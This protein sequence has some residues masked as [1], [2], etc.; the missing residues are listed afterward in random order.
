MLSKLSS[1]EKLWE[2]AFCCWLSAPRWDPCVLR[3]KCRKLFVSLPV[4]I[5]NLWVGVFCI[6]ACVTLWV[7]EAG[8]VCVLP[9][10]KLVALQHDGYYTSKIMAL[11]SHH[12]QTVSALLIL[13]HFVVPVQSHTHT[14]TLKPY[15]QTSKHQQTRLFE[16]EMLLCWQRLC[17][18]VIFFQTWIKFTF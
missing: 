4:W 3:H 2:G 11:Q 16:C 15:V 12:I 9:L 5:Y 1:C 17:E 14:H 10:C 6:W 7:E 13:T 8:C 18:W